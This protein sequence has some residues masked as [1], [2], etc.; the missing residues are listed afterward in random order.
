MEKKWLLLASKCATDGRKKTNKPSCRWAFDLFDARNCSRKNPRIWLNFTKR[1]STKAKGFN[2]LCRGILIQWIPLC[3][4]SIR[5]DW[6]LIDPKTIYARYKA[7]LD[8]YRSILGLFFMYRMMDLSIVVIYLHWIRFSAWQWLFE[9][10]G[11]DDF[12]R[13]MMKIFVNWFPI[14]IFIHSDR[15]RFI[16][17]GRFNS[18]FVC[19]FSNILVLISEHMSQAPF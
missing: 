6:Y 10:N 4:Y 19:L 7:I 1:K 5:F 18:E 15:S 11:I 2:C 12:D 13:L 14:F 8:M 9:T 17:R 3:G 16:A